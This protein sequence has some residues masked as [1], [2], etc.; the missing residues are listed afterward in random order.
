MVIIN[1]QVIM[2]VCTIPTETDG[3]DFIYDNNM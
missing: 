3:H 2:M 1:T